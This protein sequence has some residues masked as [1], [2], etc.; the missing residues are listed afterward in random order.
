MHKCKQYVSL[1]F[2][3]KQFLAWQTWDLLRLCVYGALNLVD[4]FTRRNPDYF[5]VLA[6]INGSVVESLFSQLKYAASG[7]LSSVNYAWARK[8]VMTKVNVSGQLS[9]NVDYRNDKLD[10]QDD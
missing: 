2:K 8:A 9:N 6:R 1:F 10:V 3:I 4:D 5:I 7:K